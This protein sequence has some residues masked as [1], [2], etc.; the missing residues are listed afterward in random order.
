M[1]RPYYIYILYYCHENTISA[2]DDNKSEGT[3]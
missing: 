1:S 3:S 2:E